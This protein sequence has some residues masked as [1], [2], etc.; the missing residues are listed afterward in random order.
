MR[1]N[2]NTV[3]FQRGQIDEQLRDWT[4]LTSATRPRR[5]WVKAI[6]EALGMTTRQLAERLE[7]NNS[8]AITRLEARELNGKVT[9]ESLEKAAKAM[10]CRFVYAIVPDESLE[11]TLDKRA[12]EAAMNILNPVN[13]SMRLEKQDVSKASTDRQVESLAK[14]LK[15]RL[16][17]LL[18]KK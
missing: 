7:I 18:W 16:D 10:G 12:L 2:K 1:L 8:A 13:Q 4:R 15:D 6:R 17:P 5:G 11:Q 3:H 9:I 14:Q